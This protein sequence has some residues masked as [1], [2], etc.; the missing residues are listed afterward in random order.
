VGGGQHEGP[1]PSFKRPL[2]SA[3]SHVEF[4]NSLGRQGLDRY[5]TCTQRNASWI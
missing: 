3:I 1:P 2:G 4:D 5:P